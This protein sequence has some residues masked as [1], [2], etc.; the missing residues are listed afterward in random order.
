MTGWRDDAACKGMG[1][2]L[3]FP[4]RGTTGGGF[5]LFVEAPAKTVCR[6]C[7]V[8]IPCLKFALEEGFRDGIWGGFTEKERRKMRC[9]IRRGVYP[10]VDGVEVRVEVGDCRNQWDVA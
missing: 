3:F 2:D 7:P 10:V 5:A 8:R 4:G 6:G 1:P 9:Q